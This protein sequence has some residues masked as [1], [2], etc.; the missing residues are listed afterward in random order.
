MVTKQRKASLHPRSF[1][2]TSY[3][4]TLM[5]LHQPH[6]FAVG[7]WDVHTWFHTAGREMHRDVRLQT[8]WVC[9]PLCFPMAKIQN[10]HCSE[11]TE[12]LS[13]NKVY[14][15]NLWDKLF[16]PTACT[17]TVKDSLAASVK[18]VG[19]LVACGSVGGCTRAATP[20]FQLRQMPTHWRGLTQGSSGIA[21]NKK[22]T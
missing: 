20:W 8:P 3:F 1:Q 13:G 7:D 18:W 11:G 22:S 12:S 19:A 14:S 5:R 9:S 6:S 4:C 15:T 10:L 17:R 21:V 16:S 2:N